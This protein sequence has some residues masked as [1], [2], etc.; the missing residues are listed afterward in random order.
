MTTPDSPDV[1]VLGGGYA[2]LIAAAR[3]AHGAPGTRVTLVDGRDRW[4]QR[5]RLHEEL[6][7][8]P[9]V[10]VPF[11]EFLAPQGITFLQGTVDRLDLDARTVLG[12]GAGGTP[13][14]RR[15]DHLVIALGSRTAAPAPG[16]AAHAV[17]LND[18][19]VVRE[20]AARLAALPPGA[21]VVVVGAGATGIESATE[22]AESHPTLAVSLVASGTLGPTYVAAAER[23]LRRRLAAL[24]ITL[25]EHA[26]V[27]SVEPYALR[28]ASGGAIPFDMCIWTAGFE[29]PPLLRASGLDVTADGRARVAPTLEVPAHPGVFVAGDAAAVRLGDR[30]VRAGCVSAMPLGAHAGDNVLRAL[31]GRPLEP[32][33]FEYF[34]RALSLGRDDGL[35]QFTEPDDAPREAV[36]TGAA[37]AAMKELVTRSTRWAVLGEMGHGI[38]YT[39][40]A[41]HFPALPPSAPDGTSAAA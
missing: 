35:I 19:A 17:R 11:G 20:A 21:R 14:L 27:A 23:H 24:G 25:H 9:T 15:Y 38:P 33:R 6:A 28:L 39:R 36:W 40:W 1:L 13:W 8:R 31:A 34:V 29:A 37:G 2:G 18:P 22:L 4:I 7:G 16:V 10:E 32:F 3:V 41:R 30:L 26:P 5:I 12:Y